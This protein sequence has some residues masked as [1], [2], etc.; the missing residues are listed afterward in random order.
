MPATT[1]TN[2]PVIKATVDASARTKDKAMNKSRNKSANKATAKP[3]VNGGKPPDVAVSAKTV[4]AKT[5]SAQVNEGI[6]P[7]A[8]KKKT[9]RL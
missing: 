7:V 3:K 8:V 1:V 5:N 4:P 6:K 2:N 9:V